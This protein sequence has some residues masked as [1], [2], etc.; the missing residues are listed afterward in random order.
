MQWGEGAFVLQDRES[1]DRYV[2]NYLST[3]GNLYK[4]VLLLK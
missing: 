1:K 4:A 3:Y 2:V